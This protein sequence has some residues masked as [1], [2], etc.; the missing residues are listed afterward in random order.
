M[1]APECL[2]VLH[3]SR[4]LNRAKFARGLAGPLDG[5]CVDRVLATR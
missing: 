4:P 3:T 5:K 1:G 2:P